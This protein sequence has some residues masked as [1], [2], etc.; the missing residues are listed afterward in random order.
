M[1]TLWPLTTTAWLALTGAALAQGA[2]PVTVAT[3]ARRDVPIFASGVGTVQAYRSV[4]VRARVDG[5]LEKIAFVEG[6]DVKP[7][8]PIAEIDPRPYQAVLDQARAKQAADAAQLVNM[9][10]DLARYA[11]LARTNFASQQ[12]L[13]TQQATVNQQIATLQGDSATIEAA[14]LNVQYCHITSPIE[15]VVGIRLVDEGNLIHAT[16]TAGIVTITQVHP[17]SLVF[18]LPESEFPRVRAAMQAAGSGP[19]PL[20]Q[21]Y[22]SEGGKLLSKGTLLTPNNSIDTTTGTI[23]LKA[24][25]DNTD[26]ALWPGQ[27]VAARIQLSVAHNAVSVPANAIQHGPDGLYVF[28]VTPDHVAHRHD[29]KTGYEGDGQAMVT[30]GLNG[31]EEV[32]V[33]GQVRVND[34]SPVDPRPQEAG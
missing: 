20:V 6:Q 28:T 25:F 5:T 21:A 26:R 9:K 33:S 30:D 3:A 13:N 2:P 18:T 34:G 19:G 17:I 14:A 31:G 12:Q 4:L 27:F 1:R 11:S 32:I 23:G 29:V 10:L 8:D 24:T 16:D 22:T 15:G 7:G